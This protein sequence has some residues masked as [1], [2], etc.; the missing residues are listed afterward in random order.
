[1]DVVDRDV[2]VGGED[3]D[4]ERS[5]SVVAGSRRVVVVGT[6]LVVAGGVLGTPFVDSG[7]GRTKM[8]RASVTTKMSVITTVDR[9]RRGRFTRLARRRLREPRPAA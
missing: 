6:E 4:V 3:V 5:G 1:V 8:Y 9:R 7:S 2:D